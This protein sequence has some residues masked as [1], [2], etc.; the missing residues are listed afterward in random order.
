MISLVRRKDGGT[1]AVSG[2]AAP[3]L[4]LERD[5]NSRI[6]Q[7]FAATDRFCFIYVGNEVTGVDPEKISDTLPGADSAAFGDKSFTLEYGQIS[8][9]EFKP[10]RTPFAYIANSGTVTIY[11]PRK[12]T[13]AIVGDMPP[14]TVVRFFKDVEERVSVDRKKLRRRQKEEELD[15]KARKW[16]REHWDP[17][18]YRTLRS[19]ARI[20]KAAGGLSFFALILSFYPDIFSALCFICFFTAFIPAALWPRYFSMDPDKWGEKDKQIELLGLLC[21]SG[22]GMG[23]YMFEHNY[24]PVYAP[25]AAGW[26][27]GVLLSAVL[28]WRLREH[29]GRTGRKLLTCFLMLIF[30]VGIPA[31]V[32]TM[33]DFSEPAMEQV[34]VVGTYIVGGKYK[35][36]KVKVRTDDGAEY[37]LKVSRSVYRNAEEGMRAGMEV[38]RGALGMRYA[39]YIPSSAEGT[40]EQEDG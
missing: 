10:V 20:L 21:F 37:R 8:R 38:Y 33:L 5:Q 29:H 17:K 9:L 6:Y 35:R 1:E 19:A 30:S 4:L 11:S 12:Q 40:G 2:Q 32:N 24:M 27:T 15:A 13:Y 28:I 39:R 18:R 22:A 7:V 36:Y 14:E 23:V 34:E 3:Y 31:Q 16:N 25:Y 26:V